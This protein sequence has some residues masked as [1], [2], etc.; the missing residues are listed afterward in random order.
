M[1]NPDPSTPLLNRLS[2]WTPRQALLW[3][4]GAA[5]A[6]GGIITGAFGA[7]GLRKR[8]GITPDQIHA[9]ETAASY[10]VYNGLAMMLVSLHPRFSTHRFAGPLIAA[11][12]AIFSGSIFALVLAKDRFKGL[13]PVTPMGGMVMIA[14]YDLFSI[15]SRRTDIYGSF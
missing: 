5:L 14:G 13:G 6:T 9:W 7:H 1:V 12:G 8:P 15:D 11:G 10:S 2:S 3:K 4:T